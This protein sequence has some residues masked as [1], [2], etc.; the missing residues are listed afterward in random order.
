MSHR[1]KRLGWPESQVASGSQSEGDRR[2]SSECR[3]RLF[4][5][6]GGIKI[7]TTCLFEECSQRGN[8]GVPA[9]YACAANLLQMAEEI[10]Q[11]PRV[12]IGKRDFA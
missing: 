3:A 9:P 7:M 8:P 12:Q 5:D 11:E 1:W 10:E 6:P 2:P 4:Y